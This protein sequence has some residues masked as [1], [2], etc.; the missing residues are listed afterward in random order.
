MSKTEELVDLIVRLALEEATPEIKTLVGH[1]FPDDDVWLC[2]WLAKKFIPKAANAE[3]VFINAGEFL[4]GSEK[5]PSILHFDTGGGEYDQHSKSLKRA[6]STTILAEKLGLSD[7]P[8]LKPLVEMVTAVDNIE[9][10]LPD[11]IHFTIE[12]YP[13]MFQSNGTIDWRQ[14]QERVFEL[15]DI[16]YNQATIK[17]R[18]RENLK[19]YAEWTTLPNGLK[20]ASLLWHPESREAAFEAGAAVVIW[21]QS[22]GPHYFYTGIQSNRNYPALRLNKIAAFLRFAEAQT[23]N[24]H[25]SNKDLTYTGRG[26]PISVWFLHDNLKLILNGSRSWK[27]SEDEYTKLQPRQ[28]IGLVHKALSTIPSEVVQKWNK[29]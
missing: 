2:C 14:V 25:V 9:P 10:L 11:S 21:T 20:I 29:R 18:S 7:D 19:K 1:R 27:P 13:R 15:F 28:I 24:I 23:R 17:A 16:V 8:G 4:P 5:D 22:K 3:I 12:G 6:S 26:E